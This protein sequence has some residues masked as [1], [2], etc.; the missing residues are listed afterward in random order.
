STPPVHAATD[1][2]AAKNHLRAASRNV[3][4]AGPWA[5]SYARAM[6]G[7]TWGPSSPAG[8]LLRALRASHTSRGAPLGPRFGAT[9]A[10][11]ILFQPRT[12]SGQKRRR[13][14]R[15]GGTR[16]EERGGKAIAPRRSPRVVGS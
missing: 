1:P 15:Q 14:G 7:P 13:T 5:R 10:H 11:V 16:R 9:R 8:R 6:R 3:P 4:P 12:R 2:A